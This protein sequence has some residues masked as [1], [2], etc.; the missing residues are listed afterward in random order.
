[1]YSISTSPSSEYSGQSSLTLSS[2]LTKLCIHVTIGLNDVPKSPSNTS[3][4]FP[5][6]YTFLENGLTVVLIGD[7][8]SPYCP[9]NVTLT[10]DGVDL[11]QFDN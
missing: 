6:I 1:M 11:P 5:H 2:S 7:T 4:L 3:D 10:I 9:G 8:L